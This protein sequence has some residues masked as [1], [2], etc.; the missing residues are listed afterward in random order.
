MSNEQ[1]IID[2]QIKSEYKHGW[3]TDIDMELAP[4]G[5]NE[6]TVRLISAKKAEPEWL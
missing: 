3:T 5:L 2:D 4:K 6:D 1:Q